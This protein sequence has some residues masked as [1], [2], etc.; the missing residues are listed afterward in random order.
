M[1][2]HEDDSQ[3]FPQ[4]GQIGIAAVG[5][6][7]CAA[8][9]VAWLT[10]SDTPATTTSFAP[11]QSTVSSSSSAS[12]AKPASASDTEAVQTQSASADAAQYAIIVKFRDEPVIDEI[13]KT[14]R[15]DPDSVRARF[16]AWAS[17]KPALRGLTLER[18]SYSGELV[19]TGSGSPTMDEAIS[20]IEAMDN[21]AYVEPDYS[22]QPSKKG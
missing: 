2:K 4:A 16:S 11:A 20:A 6:S 8:C 13:G 7:L 10:G 19:L 12:A 3:K 21:V 14:F 15:K 18:A 17:D 1:S 22:A 9:G 5:V